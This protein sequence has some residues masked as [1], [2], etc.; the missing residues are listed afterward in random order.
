MNPDYVLQGAAA[1]VLA[2]VVADTSVRLGV[3]LRALGNRA[4]KA[5]QKL[6]EWFDT[7][8]L[9]A[10]GPDV[11]GSLPAGVPED[12][13][14]AVVAS[15]E[16]HALV[17]E[18]LAA[19]LTDAP[20]ADV[21]RLRPLL[22]TVLTPA[23]PRADWPAFAHALF[24]FYDEQICALVGRLEGA[25]GE[26]LPRLRSEAFSARMVASLRAIERKLAAYDERDPEREREYLGRY[27]RHVVEEF[28]KIKPPDFERRR[29]V[30]IDDLY[31][32]PEILPMPPVG[33]LLATEA[34]SLWQLGEALDRSVLLGDPG[35]GKTTASGVLMHW[36]A[37]AADRRVPFLV[38]LREFAAQD[39]PERSVVGHIEHRLETFYQ[40][41]APPGL[42]S[43]LFL[44]GSAV[45]IFDGLDELT[46][47]TRR[48]EVTAIV[49]RF[50]SEYPMVRVLVTSRLVGYDQARRRAWVF[51]DAGTTSAGEKLYTFT[52]RT[53]L[54]Y[55]TA[56]YLARAHDTPEQ[57][58]KE[59]APRIIK[60]EWPVVA[61]LAL[62]MKDG[63]ADQGA[64][65][66]YRSLL[67]DKR[68]RAAESSKNLL[69]FLASALASV[70]PPPAVVRELCRRCLDHFFLGQG[71]DARYYEPLDLLTRSGSAYLPALGE[72]VRKH[73]D[74][75]V[76]DGH[77]PARTT[78]LSLALRC[79]GV[80]FTAKAT[81]ED[82]L[83]F[84][85]DFAE[86]S[87]RR[88]RAEYAAA[89]GSSENFMYEAVR[90]GTIPPGD[91]LAEPD[92]FENLL[93]EPYDLGVF[94][95]RRAPFL[96]SEIQHAMNAS[97]PIPPE[98][99]ALLRAVGE[100]LSDKADPPWARCTLTWHPRPISTTT[101]RLDG[102]AFLG[103]AIP[104][105]IL[106]EEGAGLGLRRRYPEELGSL[107]PLYPYLVRRLGIDPDAELPAL[108]VR[109][110]MQALLEAWAD[111]RQDFVIKEAKQS[112][113]R[114]PAQAR[115]SAPAPVSRPHPD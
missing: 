106:A 62:Q 92:G 58:A 114:L 21:Q 26:L 96:L 27:R 115:R 46:D 68:Y 35:G 95:I 84:W 14:E 72:E 113:R 28:G 44:T 111:G 87:R 4:L 15:D 19:R 85:A 94:A 33:S 76:A 47:T 74:I 78:A 50:C 22:E 70:D 86:E 89:A 8:E 101:V 5:D 11:S 43:R 98:R 75:A 2:R 66:F 63:M 73:I 39:P 61:E 29:R 18:L 16:F 32:S 60:Q 1:G 88:Y 13:L 54:E 31:V 93:N 97:E 82:M 105:L 112:P 42:V 79:Y 20:E 49:E 41:P 109:A 55:F 90:Q 30:P 102:M 69:S 110:D 10:P 25:D 108:P 83:A 77:E 37:Q 23:D 103:A 6:V 38:T 80:R 36:H 3:S 59:L 104:Y 45:V 17:H 24:D 34:I 67:G 64:E 65:R 57:L 7:Y 81:D 52:H 100:Y 71:N 99:I 91:L 48:A 40:C 53:F 51:S 9:D 107:A 56:G 12:A